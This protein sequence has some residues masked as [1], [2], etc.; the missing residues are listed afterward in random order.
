MSENT[1]LTIQTKVKTKLLKCIHSTDSQKWLSKYHVFYTK[2]TITH[3]T[4]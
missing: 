4:Q 2:K 1:T 3:V